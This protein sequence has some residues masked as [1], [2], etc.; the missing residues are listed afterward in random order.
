MHACVQSAGQV[1]GDLGEGVS[2]EEMKSQEA[3]MRDPDCGLSP[4]GMLSEIA[5]MFYAVLL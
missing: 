4:K 2:I 5:V 1:R 3:L